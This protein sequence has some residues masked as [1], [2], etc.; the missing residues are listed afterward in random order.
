MNYIFIEKVENGYIVSED[1]NNTEYSAPT[2]KRKVVFQTKGGL[3]NYI[4]EN[5]NLKTNENE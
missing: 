4:T 3:F 2:I 5:F 1:Y